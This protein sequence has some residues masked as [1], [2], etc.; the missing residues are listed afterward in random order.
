MVAPSSHGDLV[1]KLRPSLQ[2]VQEKFAV[3]IQDR[4]EGFLGETAIS[5]VRGGKSGVR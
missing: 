5:L 1:I 3:H 2:T 4:E